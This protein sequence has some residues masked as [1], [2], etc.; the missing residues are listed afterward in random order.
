LLLTLQKQTK[1]Q[2]QKTTKA[3]VKMAA[4]VAKAKVGGQGF[5]GPAKVAS[6]LSILILLL[7]S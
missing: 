2:K 5:K 1:K 6:R 3:K 7:S 4:E